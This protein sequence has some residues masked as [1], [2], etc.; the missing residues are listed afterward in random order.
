M[1]SGKTAKCLTLLAAL[2]TGGVSGGP[3]V[4]C[5]AANGHVSLEAEGARCCQV[6]AR[7]SREPGIAAPAQRAFFPDCDPCI[8]I[9]LL[10]GIS[11][12]KTSPLTPASQPFSGTVFFAATLPLAGLAGLCES[13]ALLARPPEPLPAAGAL[14]HLRTVVLR[15]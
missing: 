11:A 6:K 4:L 14:S 13:P 10:V 5:I 1:T 9:P 15:C 2:A 7:G 12:D 8:D 3:W